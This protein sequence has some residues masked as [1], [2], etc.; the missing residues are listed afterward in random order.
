MTKL[1]INTSK[2]LKELS[3]DNILR[4]ESKSNYCKI[5]FTNNTFPLTISKTLAWVQEQ[6]PADIF[7]RVHRTHLVNKNF[8]AFKVLSFSQIQLCNGEKINV[9]RRRKMVVNEI[10]F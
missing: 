2:G 3:F 9:S 10:S 7:L 4:V 6:V 5:F 8:I 1:N